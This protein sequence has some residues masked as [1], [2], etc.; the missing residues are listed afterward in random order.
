MFQ[1]EL[2]DGGSCAN[3]VSRNERCTS[4]CS[5]R[6]GNQGELSGGFPATWICSANWS[7]LRCSPRPY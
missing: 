2:F 5:M 7:P 6:L 3:M 4:R 1:I